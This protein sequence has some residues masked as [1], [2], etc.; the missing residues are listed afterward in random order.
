MAYVDQTVVF[1]RRG[2]KAKYMW[3]EWTDGQ[4]WVLVRG[5]DF[6]VTPEC[7]QMQALAYA[8]RNRLNV[9]TVILGDGKLAITKTG[10]WKGRR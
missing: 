10:E 3:K 2:R 5:E 9:E 6:E 7:M 8:R 1:G 4:K